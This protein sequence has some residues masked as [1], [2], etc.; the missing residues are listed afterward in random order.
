MTTIPQLSEAM[1]AVLTTTAE[2]AGR[3]VYFTRRPDTA[4][5]TASTM[6]QTLVLGYL[7]HPQATPAQLAQSAAR[8][9]VDVSPQAIVDRMNPRTA[10]LLHTVLTTSVQHLI[11]SDAPVAIPVLQRFAGVYVHDSTSIALPDDLAAPWPGCGGDGPAASLKCGVQLDLLH[12]TLTALDLAPGRT[13]DPQLPCQHRLLPTGSLRLADLGFFDLD[14]LRKQDVA[15]S[16][17]LSKL[18]ATTV[19]VDASGVPRSLWA[20]IQHLGA[21]TTWDAWVGVGHAGLRARLLVQAVPQEVA[22]QRRRRIRKEARDK[23][24]SPSAAALALAAYTILITNAP[25]ALLR[26]DEALVLA[27]VRWQIELLFKLWKSHGFLGR[28]PAP[29]SW[30]HLCAVYAQLI[31]MLLQHWVLV[32]SCWRYPDHSLVK[33][34]QVVRD[35]AT[36]LASARGQADRIAAAL[37]TI[38]TI[39]AR[40]ARLNRR[41]KRPNTY[42]LLLALTTQDAGDMA[43]FN[44]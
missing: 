33:A 35:H 34:A 13:A 1:Q 25:S 19:I 3:A 39:V 44:H 38:Q 2:A 27:K 6:T 10:A 7:T 20:F 17:F 12:G 5:F 22:N 29:N 9:E 8:A 4:K 30:Y 42:Q 21:M 28:A 43:D 14:V 16:Y 11:A 15:G 24:R 37:T 23:G 31:A 32:V 41:K 26:L 18:K 40:A 36:D